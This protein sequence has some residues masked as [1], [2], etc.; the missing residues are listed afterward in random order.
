[1]GY[2]FLPSSGSPDKGGVAFHPDDFHCGTFTNMLS[3]RSHIYLTTGD[4][5]FAGGH[6]RGKGFTHQAD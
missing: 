1:M 4:Y 3:L 6:T 2:S 5:R